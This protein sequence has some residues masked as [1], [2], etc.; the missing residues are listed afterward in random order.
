M[1]TE[2]DKRREQKLNTGVVYSR[3]VDMYEEGLGMA[4][5][6]MCVMSL[7]ERKECIPGARV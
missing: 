6:E 7:E 5:K 1:Y 3:R 4:C 2:R